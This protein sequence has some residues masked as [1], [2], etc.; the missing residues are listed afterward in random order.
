ALGRL[1]TMRRTLAQA[2]GLSSSE[3]AVIITLL[4]L[5]DGSGL[6]IRRIADELYVAAANVTVTVLKLEKGGWVA[7]TPDPL[8]SRAVAIKLTPQARTRL[9]EFAVNLHFVNDL[10]FRGTTRKQLEP[11]AS[12]FR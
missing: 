12:F 4:R 9:G 5:D 1:Q 2:L 3:V 8:D 10:W 11:A 7:K 6:R